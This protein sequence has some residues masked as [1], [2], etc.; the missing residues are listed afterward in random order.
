M[1]QTWRNRFALCILKMK[2]KLFLTAPAY[3]AWL[4]CHRQVW[5]AL[6]RAGGVL[7]PFYS[8]DRFPSSWEMHREDLGIKSFQLRNL[9]AE[10]TVKYIVNAPRCQAAI[11]ERFGARCG[12]C[13]TAKAAWAKHQD[14]NKLLHRMFLKCSDTKTDA[15]TGW[16]VFGWGSR[17]AAPL[18]GHMGPSAALC[19]AQACPCI[20]QKANY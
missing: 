18:A 15:S 1:P 6:R 7:G 17:R 13:P 20:L 12:M 2:V 8:S 9:R 5:F 11:P 4:S 3:S 10:I 14:A 19:D 16:H